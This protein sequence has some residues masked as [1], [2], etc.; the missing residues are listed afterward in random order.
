MTGTKVASR[1][2]H[3]FGVTCADMPHIV[4]QRPSSL[5]NATVEF[6]M[7]YGSTSSFFLSFLAFGGFATISAMAVGIIFLVLVWSELTAR[8]PF[9]CVPS[10]ER[11]I[12]GEYVIGSGVEIVLLRGE[13]RAVASITHGETTIPY[14]AL[15]DIH[16]LTSYL[17]TFLLVLDA[18]ILGWSRSALVLMPAP[19]AMF[20]YV[21]L[22]LSDSYILKE[23][24]QL[25]THGGGPRGVK[26]SKYMFSTRAGGV[27]F[28]LF[29]LQNEKVAEVMD[30]LLPTPNSRAWKMWKT[31]VLD[32][33]KRR[34]DFDSVISEWDDGT[35]TD[36][37]KK[38]LE[39]LFE[40]AR[41][42]HRAF[43]THSMVSSSQPLPV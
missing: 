18:L 28:A 10:A 17:C 22:Q 9:A 33:T 41:D 8:V 35:W 40:D 25:L 34:G 16:R 11:S 12:S 43:K 23:M 3:C 32:I 4:N 19:L 36:T 42:A 2:E 5:F 1:N 7:F 21:H 27:V 38:M 39:S 29:L 13:A 30:E 24:R 15:Q 14:H 6:D 31:I 26:L 20:G 37:E